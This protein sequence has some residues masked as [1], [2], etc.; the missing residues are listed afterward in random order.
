MGGIVHTVTD[1][2]G[3]TNYG[4]QE[5][6]QAQA[7]RSAAAS[8]HLTEEQVKFQRAQYEDWKKIYGPIQ[9]NLGN[10]Y[11][12]MNTDKYEQQQIEQIQI[13]FNKAAKQIDTTFAQKGL[14]DS[15]LKAATEIAIQNQA[16]MQ[17]ANVRANAD[18]IV[19]QKQMQFLG[20]GLGQGTQ[21]LGVIGNVASN[22]AASQASIA[23][24][25]IGASASMANANAN[26]MGSVIGSA[27]G[28]AALKK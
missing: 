8:L 24:A 5:E 6:A 26:A 7:S 14:E 4:A 1:A 19:A 27:L 21:M 18:E 20:L 16:A 12:N 17:K 23:G 9:D 25:N 22:G 11:M 10:F 28:Y 15:G 3:L 2:I 13:E